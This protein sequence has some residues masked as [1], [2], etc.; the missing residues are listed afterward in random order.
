MP[1]KYAVVLILLLP[2]IAFSQIKQSSDEDWAVYLGDKA[3][4]HYSTLNQIDKDNVADLEVAWTF[5]T[6][7]KGELQ[8]NPIIID[9]VL[10]TV[11]PRR[12]VVALNAASG[13]EIWRFS[14]GSEVE[15]FI[16]GRQR[17]LV[18][19]EEGEERRL[20][21]SAGGRLFALE[22]ETGEIVRSFGENGSIELRFNTPGV[23]YKDLLICGVLVNEQTP[24]SI[25]AFDV[26]TGEQK[27][28]FNTIP[29]PGEYGYHSWPPEAYKTIG[30]ASDWSGQSLDEERGILYVSTETA[31]PDFYG[32]ARHGANLF[33]NSVI[34][35]DATS[36][37]RLWHYQIVH[38][39]LLD[40]D[41]P[42]P[43]NLITVTHNGRKIDAVAQG[44]KHGLL[45]VFDRETG[46]PLW[47]IYEQPVPASDLVGEAAWPTQPIPSKPPPLMRQ[48]YTEDDVS[49]ISPEAQALTADRL[50]RSGSEGPFPAPSLNETIMFPGFDGGFEWGGSAVDPDG[51]LYANINE[52]PWIL[53]MIE[54]RHPDGSPMTR[55][56]R[57]YRVQCSTCHGIDLLGDPAGGI[58][59]LIK[60]SERKGKDEV[61]Q[62]IKDGGG[63][64]PAFDTMGQ[65]QL[66]ALVDF[67]YGDEQAS[68]SNSSAGAQ[69]EST[70]PPY[71]MTGF[72]RWFD[73]EGYP[74]IKPPWG[75]LNAVDLNTGEI[76]WKVPLGE[77][78]ELTERGIPPTGT[79][80]YGGPVITASGLLFIGAT[81]DAK[82][83]AFD[84]K[85]GKV[86]WQAEL[87]Y[88]GFAT[89]STYMVNGTQHVVI[90]AGGGKVNTPA[91]GSIVA[92]A[93]PKE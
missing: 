29:R 8:A 68:A 83:R 45:Y 2:I 77:Y 26:R 64:M 91:G 81:A 65:G 11:S 23:I 88:A 35:L 27:W 24:G 51:I 3:R 49:D 39:D 84:T 50:R 89:P 58:P 40:K 53:Q 72:R 56:E 54:N 6:G 30:G 47:P 25:R 17:G 9:G 42:Q 37:E 18:Y 38:H 21:T 52:I 28:I 14:P 31:G 32:G 60:L 78:A 74:A 36:G 71:S 1:K 63:R 59:P 93:L 20:F 80:N 55:G 82:F 62:I 92:F 79:E 41:L 33:A 16:G 34:A 19:W 85:T 46:E 5:D 61:E 13:R 67:L 87:P 70:T 4:T 57:Q 48:R 43:P 69:A 10:Y 44:T 90:S 73:D 7:E 15:A 75:T 76:L 12:T 86:L 22:V 66:D